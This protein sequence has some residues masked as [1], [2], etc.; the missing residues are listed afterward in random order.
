LAYCSN[1]N[2][3]ATCSSET[4]AEFQRTTRHYIPAHRP[5]RLYFLHQWRYHFSQ[6][7]RW[8]HRFKIWENWTWGFHVSESIML[9]HGKLLNP[10]SKERNCDGRH[11]WLTSKVRRVKKFRVRSPD[12]CLWQNQ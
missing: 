10:R 12:H 7:E 8:N 2:M 1:L 6:H 4:S 3:M 5:L 9:K 11:E